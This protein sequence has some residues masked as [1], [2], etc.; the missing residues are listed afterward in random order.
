[1]QILPNLE[2]LDSHATLCLQELIEE[3]PTNP[4]DAIV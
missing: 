3:V 1:M 4:G 2:G